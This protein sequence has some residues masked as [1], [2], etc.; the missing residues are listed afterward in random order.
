MK[1][2]AFKTL[3][4]SAAVALPMSQ[5]VAAPFVG[6]QSDDTNLEV[7]MSVIPFGPH[8]YGYAGIGIGGDVFSKAMKVDFMGL[9]ST[10]IIDDN[11]FYPISEAIDEE[12][13]DGL[14]VFNFAK[15]GSGDVWFGEWSEGGAPNFNSRSVFYVG[16]KA[17]TTMPTSGTSTYTVTGINHYTEAAANQLTGSFDVNF[18]AGEIEGSIANTSLGISVDAS[19]SGSSFSGTAEAFDVANGDAVLDANGVSEGEFYGSNA[20]ALA[21]MATFVNNSQ[22]DTAF[23]GTKD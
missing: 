10:T 6:N 16:D 14:G 11:G 13:H 1:T 19:I 18:G 22:Y 12:D 23:G 20:A 17:N 7:G 8:S 2:I 4:L 15:V 21:G 3:L 9:A 5:T